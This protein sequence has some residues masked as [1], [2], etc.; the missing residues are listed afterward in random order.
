MQA[1]ILYSQNP[2]PALPFRIPEGAIRSDTL[3]EK[4]RFG[5]QRI[6]I[7]I[8]YGNGRRYSL[9]QPHSSN[10]V[11]A[12][13]KGPISKPERWKA[14]HSTAPPHPKAG[15]PFSGLLPMVPLV[16]SPADGLKA[17]RCSYVRHF[18][19]LAVPLPQEAKPEISGTGALAKRWVTALCS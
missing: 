14:H 2:T 18:L 3:P 10:C 4:I 15:K 9:S 12:A 5:T 17:H 8:L 7:I 19:Y 13:V 11:S 1:L 16:A 6:K